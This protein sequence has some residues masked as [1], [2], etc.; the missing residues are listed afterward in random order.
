MKSHSCNSLAVSRVTQ[1]LPSWR[2]YRCIYC[3]KP[4]LPVLLDNI[5]QKFEVGRFR[6]STG[7]P[8]ANRNVGS[9]RLVGFCFLSVQAEP[10]RSIQNS[11]S[12]KTGRICFTAG[13]AR[14]L[15]FRAKPCCT[16]PSA[17]SV[18][19]QDCTRC[20]PHVQT[21]TARHQPDVVSAGT[22]SVRLRQQVQRIHSITNHS[23]GLAVW[24]HLS[25]LFLL[26]S[27]VTDTRN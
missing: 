9:T 21:V 19:S 2:G 7:N 5:W 13:P 17:K 18:F 25:S 1:M 27:A 22:V 10:P 3:T 6:S 15:W 14:K 26:H 12:T 20:L 4:Q 8:T 16:F 23:Q 24:T 11:K